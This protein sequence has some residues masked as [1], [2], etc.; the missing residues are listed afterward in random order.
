MS[1]STVPST[2]TPGSRQPGAGSTKMSSAARRNALREFYKLSSA[3]SN[4]PAPIAEAVPGALSEEVGESEDGSLS[5]A[6]GGG[7]E[8][9]AI[10]GGAG[11]EEDGELDEYLASVATDGTDAGMAAAIDGYVTKLVEHNDLKELLKKENKFAREVRTLDSEG[12]A[13]VYNN[14]SKLTAA[15]S[16]LGKLQTEMDD[17]TKGTRAKDLEEA[18]TSVA[19][20]AKSAEHKKLPP[21]PSPH[22]AKAAHWISTSAVTTIQNMISAGNVQAARDCATK[23]QALLDK[24]IK[25]GSLDS[26]RLQSIKQ[27]ISKCTSILDG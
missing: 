20:A 17:K 2:P 27:E 19:E 23:S 6:T 22:S 16:I 14:Y 21:L 7:G 13:L 1:S 15:S 12:K 8:G 11:G 18:L 24:W 3:S 26:S 4:K 10:G 25:E 5:G 9:D